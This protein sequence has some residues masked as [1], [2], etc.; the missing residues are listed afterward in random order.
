MSYHAIA[1]FCDRKTGSR[2]QQFEF[3]DIVSIMGKKPNYTQPDGRL[4]RH[5]DDLAVI[6]EPDT[7][8]IRTIVVRK[9]PKGDWEDV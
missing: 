4:V 8:V 5:Y 1:R 7:G 3:E 2:G 6:Q 9:S